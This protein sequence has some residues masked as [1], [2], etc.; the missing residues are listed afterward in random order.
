VPIVYDN[1]KPPILMSEQPYPVHFEPQDRK[2]VVCPQCETLQVVR[3]NLIVQHDAPDA[4]AV[5]QGS[6]QRVIFDVTAQ[7]ERALRAVRTVGLASGRRQTSEAPAH[8]VEAAHRV[9]EVLRVQIRTGRLRPGQSLPPVVEIARRLAV[10]E[11][12]VC[13]A[14]DL[15]RDQQLLTT[16]T[17]ESIVVSIDAAALEAKAASQRGAAR[18]RTYSPTT[19]AVHQIAAARTVADVLRVQIRTGRLA[20]GHRLRPV[21]ELARH[22]QTTESAVR[23]ALALLHEQQVLTTSPGCSVFVSATAPRLLHATA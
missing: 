8:P 11:T 21:S 13:R 19:L 22:F 17:N 18:I 5:C 6:F 2:S 1:G 23:Y 14:L 9:A 7:Q 20:P 3:Q 16:D 15:L 10:A 4:M 12:A